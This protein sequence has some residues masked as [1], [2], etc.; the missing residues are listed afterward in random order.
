MIVLHRGFGMLAP[1]FGILA[2]LLMNVVSYRLLG[3]SYYE[4][5]QWPKV[6]TLILA[7]VA[8][9]MV[10]FLLKRKRQRDG[11]V[12][13][14]PF[15]SLSLNQETE[16]FHA[17]SYPH[18]HLM[19]IPLQY[20]SIIYFVAAIIYGGVS[21]SSG[22]VK[23]Q[24]RNGPPPLQATH[25][26]KPTATA[27]PDFDEY[28]K[29]IFADQT[30]EE[31]VTVHNLAGD[32]FAEAY[33]YLKAGKTN[34]TKRCLKEILSNPE[35]EVR[36]KLLAWRALRALGEKPPANVADQVQGVVMEVPIDNAIDTLAAYADGRARYVNGNG[37]GVIL[38]DSTDES[39]VTTQAKKLIKAAEPLVENAPVYDQ[40]LPAKNSVIR[41]SILTY[42]GIHVR[43][44][45]LDYQSVHMVSPGDILMPAC[46]IGTELF[47]KLIEASRA[48]KN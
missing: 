3:A 22:V 12:E 35:A 46:D 5:H 14:Q 48:K 39:S 4:D 33:Q 7:G 25:V 32:R 45:K 40:H 44:G 43:E 8:C 6:C 29:L 23:S 15:E 13:E 17:S 38:W 24:T 47:T 28:K 41:L 19:F 2:A 18:D 9:L 27:T 37:V 16:K 42:G 36:E 10:G 1:G 30:L 31:F 20:W 26:A 11:S 21:A 34:D